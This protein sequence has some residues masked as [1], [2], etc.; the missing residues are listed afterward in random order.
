MSNDLLM[1]RGEQDGMYNLAVGEPVFLQDAAWW[2][3][4]K[5]GGPLDVRYPPYGGSERLIEQI[6]KSL[7]H[8]KKHIVVTTGAKQG[9]LA[10]FYAYARRTYQP[11]DHVL[12]QAPY[13][14]SYPTL[15]SLSGGYSMGDP[16]NVRPVPNGWSGDL[17]VVT[18]PNNPDG[19]ETMVDCDIWDAAYAHWVY[20]SKVTPNAT[21][22]VWSAAKML[23]LSGIRVGALTTD[24]ADLAEYAREYVEKTTSGVANDSQAQLANILDAMSTSPDMTASAYVKARK[25]LMTN[26]HIF[27][28]HLQRFVSEFHGVPATGRGMFAWFKAPH[29]QMYLALQKS[30]V[31]IIPGVACGAR[32]PYEIGSNGMGWW[33]MSMGHSNDYTDKALTAL[34]AALDQKL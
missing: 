5:M 19:A 33:R 30:N 31:K 13:W 34:A 20:G 12:L 1:L 27:I 15:V 25:T 23:G 14:P 16:A 11:K 18:S 8:A 7:R 26:G 28:C 2:C 21:V 24:D 4:R 17:R 22:S 9:L 6:R 3:G 29:D 10:A 32:G